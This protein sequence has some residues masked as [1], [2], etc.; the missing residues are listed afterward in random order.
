MRH[1]SPD[2]PQISIYHLQKQFHLS[3]ADMISVFLEIS[4]ND[5]ENMFERI[6]IHSTVFQRLENIAYCRN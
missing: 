2:I 4:K 1:T 5:A 6:I 3:Y